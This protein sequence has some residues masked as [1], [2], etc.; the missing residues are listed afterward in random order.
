MLGKKSGI[1]S[2]LR[3][4]FAKIQREFHFPRVYAVRLHIAAKS[5]HWQD[6]PGP[7]VFTITHP[8]VTTKD[9]SVGL[10]L[11]LT[12]GHVVA[13]AVHMS[14]PLSDMKATSRSVTCW[15][16]N[17]ISLIQPDLGTIA[18][19][20]VHD[21][22]IADIPIAV[23][24]FSCE[25]APPSLRPAEL[26]PNP[27]VLGDRALAARFPYRLRVIPLSSLSMKL[28]IRYRAQVLKST[29][30]KP[31]QVTF[32]GI[33]PSLPSAPLKMVDYETDD[34]DGF[35]Y[36]FAARTGRFN[37]YL[38]NRIWVIIQI[39]GQ[40]EFLPIIAKEE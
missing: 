17:A 21:V 25:L 15:E 7:E 39:K 37:S 35:H 40:P 28:Q 9:A 13:P 6:G 16:Q 22:V 12:A 23:K 18:A 1:G 20:A 10:E 8:S 32:V 38:G 34:L 24:D 33:C 26:I 3:K 27:K 2:R 14:Q 36:A 31:N 11:A 5:N 4:L 29:G 30:L 19:P